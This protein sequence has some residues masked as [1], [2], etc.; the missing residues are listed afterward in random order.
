MFFGLLLELNMFYSV[1]KCK[2]KECK[3][4]KNI[5]ICMNLFIGKTKKLMVKSL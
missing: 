2:T 1:I 4:E 3:T 5:V